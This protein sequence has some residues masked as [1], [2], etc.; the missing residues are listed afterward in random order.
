M[1]IDT[2]IIVKESLVGVTLPLPQPAHKSKLK[3]TLDQRTRLEFLLK[4]LR[5]F[6]ETNRYHNAAYIEAL[7]SAGE[8]RRMQFSPSPDCLAVVETILEE[9]DETL[10]PGHL[11]VLPGKEEALA[12][13]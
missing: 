9:T 4:K 2:A 7:L 12:S 8:D 3:L 11:P 5:I 13:D 6:G 10:L 1:L